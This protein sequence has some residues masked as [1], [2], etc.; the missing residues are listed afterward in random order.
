MQ[1]VYCII[2]VVLLVMYIIYINRSPC[3]HVYKIC[4]NVT[5]LEAILKIYNATFAIGITQLATKA[6]C[7]T[8][9]L[10]LIEVIKL[11]NQKLLLEPLHAAIIIEQLASWVQ[12][13][14]VVM[15]IYAMFS[16]VLFVDYHFQIC[17]K[18]V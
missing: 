8:E 2:T 16:V 13:L 17:I 6:L 18:L 9:L 5:I 11:P 7:H 12:L 3:M 4:Q 14:S 1:N 15:N 10:N